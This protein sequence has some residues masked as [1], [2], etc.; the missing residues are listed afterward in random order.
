MPDEH[1]SDLERRLASWQPTSQGLDTDAMLY[2][3]GQASVRQSRARFVWPTLAA[4]LAVA[5]GWLGMEVRRGRT[6]TLALL[7][8]LGLPPTSELTPDQQ[9]ILPQSSMVL[10]RRSLERDPEFGLNS[11]SISADAAP[12]IPVLRAGNRDLEIPQ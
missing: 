10:V 6:E 7:A 2:A 5:V 11:A 3:A 1:L 4:C 8:R 9:Y 12:S